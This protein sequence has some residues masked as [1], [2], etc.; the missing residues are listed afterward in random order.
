MNIN[1]TYVAIAGAALGGAAVA[2]VTTYLVTKNSLKKKYEASL[3]STIAALK[4]EYEGAVESDEEVETEAEAEDNADE[5]EED[6]SDDDEESDGRSPVQVIN[7]T[8]FSKGIKTPNMP[9]DLK[10]GVKNLIGDEDDDKGEEEEFSEPP[11]IIKKPKPYLIMKDQF[12]DDFCEDSR[13][14]YDKKEL[15][16][17][18][19]DYLYIG[20]EKVNI[21][22][23][24]S[25]DDDAIIDVFV[26]EEIGKKLK[27]I[28]V[29]KTGEWARKNLDINIEDFGHPDFDYKPYE[30]VKRF[31]GN[32]VEC[33][34]DKRDDKSWSNDMIDIEEVTK[35]NFRD[36]YREL[37]QKPKEE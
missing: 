23:L 13:P 33:Y 6:S 37:W 36:V 25:C 19:K 4:A 31:D 8:S 17:F 28:G 16:L 24:Y 27:S 35:E 2:G 10:D 12:F 14:W 18:M 20:G 3:S 9:K 5:S 11:E 32:E 29:Q 15:I 30:Q 21:P 34:I 1:K 7:Y 22:I 26:D